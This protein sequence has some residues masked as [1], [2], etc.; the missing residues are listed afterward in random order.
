V[1]E[2]IKSGHL[3][4]FWGLAALTSGSVMIAVAMLLLFEHGS[5]AWRRLSVAVW[6]HSA[7]G[8][9]H[10]ALRPFAGPLVAVLTLCFVIS[11]VAL[12]RLNHGLPT[13][14]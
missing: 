7:L 6:V 4:E 11:A 13:P 10:S 9:R 1:C 8:T 3:S 12:M 14:S 2:L 5:D